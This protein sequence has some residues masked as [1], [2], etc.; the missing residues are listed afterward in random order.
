MQRHVEIDPA[1]LQRLDEIRE[2]KRL[3]VVSASKRR[4]AA[5][6]ELQRASEALRVA[7]QSEGDGRGSRS[8]TLPGSD[9]SGGMA[10]ARALSTARPGDRVRYAE[11]GGGPAVDLRIGAA[12]QENQ[13]PLKT[14]E[15]ASAEVDMGLAQGRLEEAEGDEERATEESNAAANLYSRCVEYLLKAGA[16]LPSSG[17]QGPRHH[18][19]H[20]G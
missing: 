18:S 2:V 12:D 5:Y 14:R 13:R 3:S 17:R 16:N 1:R 11:K 7:R 20:S 9:S 4:T 19:V 6:A 10:A 8:L 15:G